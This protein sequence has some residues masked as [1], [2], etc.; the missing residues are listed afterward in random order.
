LR[1]TESTGNALRFTQPGASASQFPEEHQGT[2]HGQGSHH[3][4][5][6]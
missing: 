3:T 4:S 6:P 2:G 5:I 1:S